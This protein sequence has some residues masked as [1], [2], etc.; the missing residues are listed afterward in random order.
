MPAYSYVSTGIVTIGP[1][2]FKTLTLS[3]TSTSTQVLSITKNFT[4]SVFNSLIISKNF[5]YSVGSKV[6]RVFRVTGK[7]KSSSVCPPTKTS[8]NGCQQ[9]FVVNVIA[10]DV[11]G[12]CAKLSE[13][14]F[15]WPIQSVEEFSLPFNVSDQLPGADTSCNSLTDVTD[16]FKNASLSCSQFLVDQSL[17]QHI[18]SSSNLKYKNS[19]IGSGSL[20]LSGNNKPK[21]VGIYI[22]FGS[23]IISGTVKS[24]GFSYKGSGSLLLDGRYSSSR[25]FYNGSGSLVLGGFAR[26]QP[27]F[28]SGLLLLSGTSTSTSR[29]SRQGSGSLTIFGFSYSYR[30]NINYFGSGTLLLSGLNNNHPG[31]YR[32]SGSLLLSGNSRVISTSNQA[33]GTGFLV[34]GGTCGFGYKYT[35]SG[36]LLISGSVRVNNY[37]SGSGS[38]LL[39][40]NSIAVNY[41]YLYRGSGSLLLGGSYGSSFLGNLVTFIGSQTFLVTLPP[42]FNFVP[43]PL[44]TASSFQVTTTCCPYT[45]PNTLYLTNNLSSLY[46]FSNF[47]YRNS[48]TF[49]STVLLT[50]NGVNWSNGWYYSGLADNSSQTETW[51]ILIT[52]NCFVSGLLGVSQTLWNINIKFIQKNLTLGTNFVTKVTYTFPAATVCNGS[53]LLFPF[54]FNIFTQVT[55]PSANTILISDYIGMFESTTVTLLSFIFSQSQNSFNVGNIDLAPEIP[56]LLTPA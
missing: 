12:V 38:L 53:Q 4:Y 50:Y 40:G 48:K 32:G 18:G 3:G 1:Y 7:C 8:G 34:L 13:M 37:I 41:N 10:P 33:K 30:R 29:L 56:A 5:T 24:S 11:A 16:Q 28:G 49:P 27:Y 14:N 43:A 36:S 31:Q 46:K 52:A 26:S 42:I 15:V 21:V 51:N 25:N 39:S 9:S 17:V 45:L 6:D 44:L 35:G 47:L 2:S 23:L 54:N 19:Y 55:T 20:I 22:G